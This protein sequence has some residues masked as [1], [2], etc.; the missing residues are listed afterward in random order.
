MPVRAFANHVRRGDLRIW[1]AVTGLGMANLEAARMRAR[2]PA[3]IV[4]VL[5]IGARHES[6]GAA[7]NSR[8]KVLSRRRD[9]LYQEPKSSRRGKWQGMKEMEL[10][11]ADASAAGHPRLH[12]AGDRLGPRCRRTPYPARRQATLLVR[13]A[14]WS[15]PSDRAADGE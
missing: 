6:A 8:Q 10:A 1:A 13:G 11:S 5:A 15:N 3:R 14:H 7:N 12:A 4:L 9:T 2:A